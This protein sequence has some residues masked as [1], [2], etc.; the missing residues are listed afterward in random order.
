[1]RLDAEADVGVHAGLQR[2]VGI[3]QDGF[4]QHG[5]ARVLEHTGKTRQLARVRFRAGGLG[6]DAHG[7]ARGG[8]AGFALR[9]GGLHA[10]GGEVGQHEERGRAGASTG[11]RR[12]EGADIDG[13]SA[14]D[15]GEGGTDQG[16]TEERGVAFL[17]GLGHGELGGRG[18]DLLAGDE[19]GR[20]LGGFLQAAMLELG[21]GELGAGARLVGDEFRDLELG[22]HL[23]R[24]HAVADVGPE[25]LDV[26]ADL[27]VQRDL[28]VRADFAEQLDAAGDVAGLEPRDGEV[29][30]REGERAEEEREELRRRHGLFGNGGCGGRQGRRKGRRVRRGP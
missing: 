16:E 26:A 7:L 6:E 11:R 28:L 23:A 20:L 30:G 3:G 27:G 9:Q 17:R 10:H 8:Q 12:D 13:A 22:E 15:A 4:D 18:V 21:E 24:G 29:G 25:R 19:V 1:M 2:A 14:D 5:L